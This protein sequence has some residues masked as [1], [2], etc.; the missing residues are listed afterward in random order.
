M[1]LCDTQKGNRNSQ[2]AFRS[3]SC[4]SL[5]KAFFDIF[6]TNYYLQVK[7]GEKKY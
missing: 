4:P 7:S 2:Q 6:Q 3:L 1:I 5:L